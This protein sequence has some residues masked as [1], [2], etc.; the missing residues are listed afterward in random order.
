[1]ALNKQQKEFCRLYVK[2]DNGT[3]A[4]AESGYKSTGTAT[5]L[6]KKEEVIEYIE[7]LR[8]AIPKEN[9]I[10][11][12]MNTAEEV[13]ETLTLIAEKVI[14]YEMDSKTA[15]ALNS[16]C[17]TVLNSIRTDELDK[18]MT[19]LKQIIEEMTGE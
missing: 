10:S 13:R 19:E 6:L 16:L 8:M 17:T 1:M 2:Y 14:N 3:K 11:L 18:E 7:I 12:K 4:A 15:A 5:K 9:K